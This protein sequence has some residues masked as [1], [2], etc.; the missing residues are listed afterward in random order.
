MKQG[1]QL[2]DRHHRLHKIKAWAKPQCPKDQDEGS[3]LASED[4]TQLIFLR[5]EMEHF[6]QLGQMRHTTA[7]YI[8]YLLLVSID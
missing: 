3:T 8:E 6:A 5:Q 1:T 2:L 4:V 7:L